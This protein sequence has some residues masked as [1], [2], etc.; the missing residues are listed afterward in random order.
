MEGLFQDLRYAIRSMFKAPAFT[1]AAVV[2]LVLGV[3]ANTAIFTVVHAVLLRPLPYRDAAR[4][5]QLS[6]REPYSPIAGTSYRSFE[7][8]R[9]QS[10]SFEDMAVYYKNTGFSRVVISGT[11]EPEVAAAG[12]TSASFFS[13]LGVQPKI[14][15]VFTS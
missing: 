4:V 7:L 6:G 14:G 9:S 10:H 5:V 1:L 15:R 11:Q 2:T 12:F 8:W 13:L 3:G